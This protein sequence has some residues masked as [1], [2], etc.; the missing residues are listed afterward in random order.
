VKKGSPAI[1]RG[2]ALRRRGRRLV[3]H[4]L[5][6]IGCVLFVDALVGEKG[7]LETRRKQ[8]EYEQLRQE[9]EQL[10]AENAELDGEIER[11]RTD[12]AAIEDRARR[13][14]GLVKPGEKVFILKD[15]E[16]GQAH[17]APPPDAPAE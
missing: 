2:A 8:R 11:L 16:P 4:G 6:F 1:G 13:D 7:L 15:I 3:Q 10:H 5:V 12:P 17:P 9:I 14:L